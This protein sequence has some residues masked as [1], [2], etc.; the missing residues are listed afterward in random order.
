MKSVSLIACLVVLA[1]RDGHGFSPTKLRSSSVKTSSNCRPHLSLRIAEDGN[2]EVAKL[3]AAAAKA[4]EEAARLA[5]VRFFRS[6]RI[7]APF[8]MHSH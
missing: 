8:V 7:Y 3:M 5:K 4:R 1:A 6:S 2:D